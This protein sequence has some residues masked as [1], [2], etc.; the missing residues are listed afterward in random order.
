MVGGD[1]LSIACSE[2][3]LLRNA[4]KAVKKNRGAAGPDGCTI[5]AF[6]RSSQQRLKRMAVKLRWGDYRFARMRN[7]E[8]PKPNGGVRRLSIPNVSDR[9][10]LQAIRMVIEPFFEPLMSRNSHGFRP[11]RGAQTALKSLMTSLRSG[12][13]W[14]LET[15]IRSF[16]DSIDHTSLLRQIGEIT[17]QFSCSQLLKRSLRMTSRHW[18]WR[19][20]APPVAG[21]AQ[22]SPLSPL[23][24]NC[25]LL[26]FDNRLDAFSKGKL[27]RYVDDLVVLC[28]SQ[29]FA[30][31]GQT[32]VHQTLSDLKLTMH[33]GKTRIV[34]SAAEPFEF[35]GFEI[36][37]AQCRPSKSNIQ[38]L[39]QRL[40]RA[41][42]GRRRLS[43]S[44]RI[45][46]LAPCIRSFAWYFGQCDK[47][48]VFHSLDAEIHQRM[49]RIIVDRK[50]LDT[51]PRLTTLIEKWTS[52]TA[53]PHRRHSSKRWNGDG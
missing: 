22:G 1:A 3:E 9:V 31:V 6:E 43:G 42:S 44:A 24:S 18:L 19:I 33:P 20:W 48:N 17:P 25:F 5:S 32:L 8:S 4:W 53:R 15:D 16:F 36:F 13:K 30:R 39:R 45:T 47:V 46:E 34:D 10:I 52:S 7:I 2:I 50:L 11:G 23:L 38:K 40:G 14:V 35:L 12:N 37:Q 27:V 26:P 29:E 41:V 21:L 49:S 28:P 51:L